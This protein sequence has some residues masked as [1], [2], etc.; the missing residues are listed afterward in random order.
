MIWPWVWFYK[1]SSDS[2][3]L[4][5]F[6]GRIINIKKYQSSNLSVAVRLTGPTLVIL[7]SLCFACVAAI[8]GKSFYHIIG[9]AI[10]VVGGWGVSVAGS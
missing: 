9:W 4:I 10:Q 3:L 8:V 7:Q 5:V 6:F 1:V 2:Y